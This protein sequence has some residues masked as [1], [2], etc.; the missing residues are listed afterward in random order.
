MHVVRSLGR[1]LCRLFTW[2]CYIF[3]LCFFSAR[4]WPCPPPPPPPVSPSAVLDRAPSWVA[5]AVAMV[6]ISHGCINPSPF[7]KQQ[8]A[9]RGTNVFHIAQTKRVPPGLA[10]RLPSR[11]AG[12]WRCAPLLPWRVQCPAGVCA[13]LAAGLGGAGLVPLLVPPPLL[14]LPRVPRGACGGSSRPGVPCP[15]LLVRHSMWSVR[16]AGSVRLPFWC[17]PRARCVFVRSCSRSVRVSPPP[18]FCR[19]HTSRGPLAGRWWGRSMRFVPLRVSC[20][21]PLLSLSCV[22]GGGGRPGPCASLPVSQWR[23]PVGSRRWSAGRGPRGEVTP[24]APPPPRAG[25]GH[26][27]HPPAPPRGKVTPAPSSSFMANPLPNTPPSSA[28]PEGEARGLWTPPSRCLFCSEQRHELN[29]RNWL[30][31]L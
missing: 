20:S 28:A 17:A 21:S 26:T 7:G 1:C 5:I 15:R 12:A 25:G 19:A 2:H 16:S 27:S 18:L 4:H 29:F 14:S 9:I 24:A 22:G 11:G 13:A 31:C 6:D 10:R 30:S 8:P 23:S 3:P